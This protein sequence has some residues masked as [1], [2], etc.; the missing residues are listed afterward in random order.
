MFEANLTW[1]SFIDVVKEQYYPVGNYDYWYYMRWT[2]LHQERDQI[3]LE[4]T[5]TFH[6][7]CTKIGIKDF[8][9]NLVLKYFG[10]IHRYIQTKMKHI[11]TSSLHLSIAITLPGQALN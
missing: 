3:V 10:G 7:L 4:F 1:A 8:E 6:T 2:T 5:N 11:E 9:Q